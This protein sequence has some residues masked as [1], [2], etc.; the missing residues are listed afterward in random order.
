MGGERNTNRTQSS[1]FDGSAARKRGSRACI[2]ARA[3]HVKPGSHTIVATCGRPANGPIMIGSPISSTCTRRRP[4]VW[5]E[6]AVL[7]LEFFT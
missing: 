6:V 1:A 2:I 7:G 3:P 5:R 4:R